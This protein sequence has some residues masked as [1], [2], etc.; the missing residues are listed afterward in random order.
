V[1][2]FTAV[3]RWEAINTNRD[4][5]GGLGQLER[6]TLGLNFRP[7]EDTVFKIDYQ[8]NPEALIARGGSTVRG[9]DTGFLASVATYF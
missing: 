3:V 7:T 9:H 1:S 5:N 2:T 6:L 8:Y 4:F